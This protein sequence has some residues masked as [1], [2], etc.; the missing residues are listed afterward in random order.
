MPHDK[1]KSR[2]SIKTS[3]GYS[4]ANF[5]KWA[6]NNPINLCLNLNLADVTKLE[7]EVIHPGLIYVY[8]AGHCGFHKNFGH[9]EVLVDPLNKRFCSDH[10]RVKVSNCKADLIL[11]PVTSCDWQLLRNRTYNQYST[12]KNK[13]KYELEPWHGKKI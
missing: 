10:C 7:K 11:A 9:I 6:K 8:K 12:K 5:L 13:K 4:A 2:W 3:P 1:R